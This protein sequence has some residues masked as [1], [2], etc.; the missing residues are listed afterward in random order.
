MSALAWRNATIAV[1]SA[2]ATIVVVVAVI[3][4]SGSVGSP[5]PDEPILPAFQTV[6]QQDT[7]TVDNETSS[8][9]P[10]VR[11]REAI[12]TPSNCALYGGVDGLPF[13]DTNRC[14]ASNYVPT[15]E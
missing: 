6:Q 1:A 11:D 2:L 4:V 15:V 10:V 7:S 8:Q 14:L 13:L 5:V 3:L 12:S 9:D